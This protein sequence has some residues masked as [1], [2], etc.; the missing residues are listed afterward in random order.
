MTDVFC[1]F[2]SFALRFS[3][4]DNLGFLRSSF[5]A[6]SFDAMVASLIALGYASIIADSPKGKNNCGKKSVIL[7]VNVFR[8]KTQNAGVIG[9]GNGR[10]GFV[11]DVSRE[12]L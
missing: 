11:Q 2:S 3:L 8:S 5:P 4:T 9:L 1:F 6:L 10:G 12:H 7:N